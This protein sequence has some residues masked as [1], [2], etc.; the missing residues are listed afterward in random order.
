M[1]VLY[2]IQLCMMK[3]RHSLASSLTFTLISSQQSNKSSPKTFL[4]EVTSQSSQPS[5]GHPRPGPQ[6]SPLSRPQLYSSHSSLDGSYMS[7]VV[8]PQSLLL[9]PGLSPH[10]SL[11]PHPSLGSVSSFASSSAA[12]DLPPIE[13]SPWSESSLDQPYEKSKKKRSSSKKR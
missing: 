9:T 1:T 13:N 11:S 2:L 5:S 7:P 10:R 6:D 12:Y 3:V 4:A 8:T